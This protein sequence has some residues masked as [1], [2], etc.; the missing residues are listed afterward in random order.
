MATHALHLEVVEPKVIDAESGGKPLRRNN[1]DH[2]V[3]DAEGGIWSC[4]NQ[5]SET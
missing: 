1:S 2:K 3:N 4:S 5:H